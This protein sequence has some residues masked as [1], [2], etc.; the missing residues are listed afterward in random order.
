MPLHKATHDLHQ[1][2]RA[3]SIAL[4]AQQRVQL[5]TFQPCLAN[6]DADLVGRVVTNLLANALKFAPADGT[7]RLTL[8]LEDGQVR[9]ALTDTGRGI[10]PEYHLRI[11]EK[12]GQAELRDKHVGTG[13]GLAFCKL[14][15]EAH[16]G[17]IGVA[18]QPGQGSTFW[19]TLPLGMTS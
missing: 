1:T 18:S 4:A 5:P 13:L 7:V 10:A 16:G 14:A 15:V 3:A 19:F 6:Y 17:Q 2:L 8:G 11:F 12:F 9:V